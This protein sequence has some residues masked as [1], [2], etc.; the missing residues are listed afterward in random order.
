MQ[1]GQM[2]TDGSLSNERN[3]DMTN[4]W[5]KVMDGLCP[6]KEATKDED[7]WTKKFMTSK[8]GAFQAA[9]R[10]ATVGP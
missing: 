9:G 10:G 3:D 7:S 2:K 1:Q 5:M 8:E 6:M 4:S